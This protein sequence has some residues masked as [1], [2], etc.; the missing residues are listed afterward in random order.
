[1]NTQPE[2]AMQDYSELE[3]SPVPPLRA[4]VCWAKRDDDDTPP[5]IVR[6][7]LAKAAADEWLAE[8]ERAKREYEGIGSENGWRFHRPYPYRHFV[9]EHE[10]AS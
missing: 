3:Y 4:Y 7:V 5:T 2:H 10:V 8:Q 9:S 1:M 6:I